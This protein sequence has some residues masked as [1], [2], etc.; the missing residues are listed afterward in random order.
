[1]SLF[2][3]T[4]EDMS[5]K[6][7]L[8][9]FAYAPQSQGT[10]KRYWSQIIRL[11]RLNLGL[12]LAANCLMVML[13]IAMSVLVTVE[14]FVWHVSGVWMLLYLT[15]LMLVRLI[16]A[17][18]KLVNLLRGRGYTLQVERAEANQIIEEAKRNMQSAKG[19]KA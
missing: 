3:L 14:V 11:G 10:D 13:L 7:P 4:Q 12:I 17:T 18:I 15:L 9:T 5:K 8:F 19:A 16:P 2:V 1:M 6:S